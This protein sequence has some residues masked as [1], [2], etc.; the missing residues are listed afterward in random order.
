MI[1]LKAWSRTKRAW[2]PHAA[3]IYGTPD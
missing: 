1:F 2:E 3:L